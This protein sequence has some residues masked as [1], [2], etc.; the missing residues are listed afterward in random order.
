MGFQDALIVFVVLVWKQSACG[1]TSLQVEALCKY[2][3]VWQGA[4]RRRLFLSAWRQTARC[5][6]L[7]RWRWRAR[8]LALLR[9]V[10]GTWR[11]RVFELKGT[12]SNSKCPAPA[13]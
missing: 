11:L 1:K 10:V 13:K 8:G 4:V 5:I 6:G 2:L 9:V 7:L 12:P 3:T